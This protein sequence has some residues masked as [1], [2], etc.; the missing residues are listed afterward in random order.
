MFKKPQQK[1]TIAARIDKS[2]FT[3]LQIAA[4]AN[5]VS[6]SHILRIAAMSYIKDNTQLIRETAANE[7]IEL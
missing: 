5:G 1:A 2:A 6:I 3:L 4:Y 7:G